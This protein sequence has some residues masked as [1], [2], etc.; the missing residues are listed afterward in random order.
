MAQQHTTTD[1]D[2]IRQHAKDREM[3]PAQVKNEGDSQ[4]KII[5]LMKPQSA[6]SENENLTRIEWEEWFKIFEK[7]GLALIFEEGSDFNKLVSR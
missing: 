1:H 3:Q 2:K 7:Q 6:H 4:Q 5:R